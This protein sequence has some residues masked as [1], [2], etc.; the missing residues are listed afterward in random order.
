MLTIAAGLTLSLR[1]TSI[2]AGSNVT[3]TDIGEHSVDGGALLCITDI[4]PCCSGTTKQGNWT[5]PNNTV[6]GRSAD[7]QDFYVTRNNQLQVLLHRRNHAVRPLGIYCCKL[8][9]II[10]SDAALCVNL[11]T[12]D[13]CVH[14]NFNIL[15]A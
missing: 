6:I 10:N 9:T 1:S 15:S 11:S 12:F 14:C 3:I 5:F 7:N 8:P 4:I 13:L 2:A